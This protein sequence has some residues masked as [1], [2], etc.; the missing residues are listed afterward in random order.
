MLH[1]EEF[2]DPDTECPLFSLQRYFS[3]DKGI[4]KYS[5]CI[6]DVSIKRIAEGTPLMLGCVSQKHPSLLQRLTVP[7]NLA[8]SDINL[9]YLLHKA[10]KGAT[11]LLK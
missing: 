8:I 5:K 2:I 7:H 11:A 4:L 10:S 9:L 3:L 1:I 6:A